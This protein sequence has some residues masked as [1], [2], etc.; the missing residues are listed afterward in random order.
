MS[1]GF[2]YE[3]WVGI[4][5]RGGEAAV[6]EWRLPEPALRDGSEGH[7]RRSVHSLLLQLLDFCGAPLLFGARLS[8]TAKKTN[9]SCFPEMA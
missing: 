1:G 7:E 8:R 3:D 9:D 4:T 5:L 2:F 6:D